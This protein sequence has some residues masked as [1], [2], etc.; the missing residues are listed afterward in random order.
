MSCDHTG[1]YLSVGQAHLFCRVTSDDAI[2]SLALVQAGF[3]F[4]IARRKT[5]LGCPRLSSFNGHGV[6]KQHVCESLSPTE[7]TN[8]IEL[9]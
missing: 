3:A 6:L 4:R 7:I 1:D 2:S 5:R 8:H 9:L